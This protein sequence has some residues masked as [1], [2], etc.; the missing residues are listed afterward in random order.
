MGRSG[1]KSG[2]GWGHSYADSH[3]T[4]FRL[5]S[6]LEKFQQMLAIEVEKN[7]SDIVGQQAGTRLPIKRQT[8]HEAFGVSTL[9]IRGLS[10]H[11]ASSR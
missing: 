10:E 2:A 1:Q 8:G 6:Q 4:I 3:P 9:L 7:G 5:Q 11:P